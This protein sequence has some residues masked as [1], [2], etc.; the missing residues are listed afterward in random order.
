MIRQMKND[1]NMNNEKMNDEMMNDEM[2]NDEMMNDEM[3]TECLGRVHAHAIQTLRQPSSLIVPD[4]TITSKSAS[5]LLD[6][7]PERGFDVEKTTEHLLQDI[8]PALNGSS[9]LPTYYGFVTGGVTP[10][11]RVGESLVSIYDQNVAV[12]LPRE[13]V[14]SVVE[15]KALKL[16]LDLFHL[17]RNQWSGVFTT[18]ATAGNVVGLALGREYVVN[19]AIEKVTGEANKNNT[20]GAYGLLRACRLAGIEDVVVL[21]TRPHSSLA[22]AASIV[23]LGRE[24]VV[25]IGDEK[26]GLS[27]DFQ[28]L[29]LL[30]LERSGK[31]AFIVAVSCGEVNTGLFATNSLEQMQDLRTLCDRY[32]AWL[33]VDGGESHDERRNI[34]EDWTDL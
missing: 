24:S 19:R 31:D 22:K 7:L 14:A 27:F 3:M 30:M 5:R 12:H 8:A 1:E 2:M 21:T 23:G 13:T 29:E 25:D 16:L 32:G 28:R 33:H 15:D 18:G 17:D 26:E 20:V 10:A 11:A 4:Q 6:Q 34:A 9:L